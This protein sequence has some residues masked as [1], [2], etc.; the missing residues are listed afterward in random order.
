MDKAPRSAQ[1]DDIY[2]TADDGL[3]ETRHVFLAGNNL[4]EAWSNRDRFTI[5]ETGFGTGLNFLETWTRFEKTAD[6]GAIL[7][8]VSFE[9]YP[10]SA[11]EIRESLSHWSGEF[12]GRLE[13]LVRSYPLRIPGWH[14]V[15]LG[16]RVRL[17]LVFDDVNAALP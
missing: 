16:P 17:T 15:D 13:K 7:D 3:A 10:W 11:K 6:S 9:L 8:Y 2:F 4:P 14:R 5:A 12:G 1:F